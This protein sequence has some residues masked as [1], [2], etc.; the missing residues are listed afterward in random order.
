MGDIV[1]HSRL[2][3]G[4][5]KTQFG[6]WIQLCEIGTPDIVAICRNKSNNLVL[7]FIETKRDEKQKLRPEQKEFQQKYLG[8]SDIY[9]LIIYD[10]NILTEF[11]NNL[12][13]DRIERITL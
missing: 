9:Y 11:I 5:I 10:L 12:I 4:R 13:P 6:T 1:W 8:Y 7:I 2:N 3:S